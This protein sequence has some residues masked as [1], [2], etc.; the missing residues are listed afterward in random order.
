MSEPSNQRT[1][2]NR[3]FGDYR[4]LLEFL[5][6]LVIAFGLVFGVVRPVVATPVYVG[7]GSM[8]PTLHGCKGCNNDRVLINKF[9]YDFSDPKRGDIIL[10][11]SLNPKEPDDELIK[12]VIG[13]PGDTIAIQNGT[14]YLNG[15]PQDEPYIA[16]Q[17]CVAYSP[18]TCSFGPAKVP[19]NHL[20]V[21]G[22]NRTGSTDSRF[23]G[24]IPEESVIGKAALSFWPPGRIQRL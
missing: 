9:I 23:F 13:L 18:K 19:E 24:P 10:F 7:S 11:E 12:R 6:M 3:R 16:A 8:E 22:D 5:L 20:F 14:V 17:P 15:K 21:M 2:N 1:S 4:G